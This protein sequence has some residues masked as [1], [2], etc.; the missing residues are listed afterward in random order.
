MLN[1]FCKIL[2]TCI[3]I[4]YSNFIIAA[5]VTS[6]EI[7]KA[8][9]EMS[10][11]IFD[12]ARQYSNKIKISDI[13]LYY[14]TQ[15]LYLHTYNHPL[16]GYIPFGVNY[17]TIKDTNTLADIISSREDYETTYILLCLANSKNTLS[18]AEK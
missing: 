9:S 12:K 6:E 11:R 16:N 13:Y 7:S 18:K 2:V 3:F 14:C 1:T 4:T 8:Q 10:N 15:E 17:K 5:D